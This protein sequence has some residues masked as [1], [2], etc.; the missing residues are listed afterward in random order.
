[1]RPY[2]NGCAVVFG[3]CADRLGGVER[4]AAGEHGQAAEER[5]LR[6]AQQGVTPGDRVAQRPLA[7]GGI[8]WTAGEHIEATLKPRTQRRGWQ[9]PHTGRG[10]LN[11]ERQ[12]VEPPA[13]RHN[14]RRVR[15]VQRKLASDRL[16]SRTEQ[17]HRGRA[18]QRFGY[19][20]R[21]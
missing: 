4:A 20:Q 16:G 14:I 9:H 6:R 13:D 11:G 10:Q 21:V 3:V 15:V 19:D 17:R 18:E 7:G 5:L 2:A 8:A 1:M 12:A